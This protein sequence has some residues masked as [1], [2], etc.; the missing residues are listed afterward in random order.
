MIKTFWKDWWW[1]IVL[2]AVK[3]TLQLIAAGN[4]GFHRDEYLYLAEAEHLAWGYL[5]VP[6]MIAFLGAFIRLFGDGIYWIK[7]FPA[8]FGAASLI[9]VALMVKKPKISKYIPPP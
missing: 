3:L 7:L 5:E 2:V 6:P 1:L 9:Y 4:Y 8:L